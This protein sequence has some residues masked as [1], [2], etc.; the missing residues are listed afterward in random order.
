M[1][2]DHP[3]SYQIVAAL[4]ISEWFRIASIP[5]LVIQGKSG[6]SSWLIFN[7]MFPNHRP[8]IERSGQ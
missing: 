8:Y 3:N 7:A 2:R 1:T 6:I 4:P 5:S